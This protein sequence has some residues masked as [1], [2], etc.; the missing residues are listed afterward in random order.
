MFYWK[1]ESNPNRIRLNLCVVFC[2]ENVPAITSLLGRIAR[3]LCGC[4]LLLYMSHCGVVT[5]VSCVEWLNWSPWVGLGGGTRAG[6]C[7]PRQGVVLRGKCAGH[8]WSIRT[9]ICAQAATAV[10]AMPAWFWY[11]AFF[12][13][14]SSTIIAP[15]PSPFVA[16]IYKPP[17]FTL[18]SLH[19]LSSLFFSLPFPSFPAPPSFLRSTPTYAYNMPIQLLYRPVLHSIRLLYGRCYATTSC[20]CCVTQ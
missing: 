10:C 5:Q 12:Y 7:G 16:A 11:T 4:G 2:I 13:R 14:L 8:L 18:A 1:N 3:A 6:S 19:F 15:F 9:F 17:Y 20:L